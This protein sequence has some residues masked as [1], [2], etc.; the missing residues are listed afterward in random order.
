M[1]E[2]SVSTP[3]PEL[4]SMREELHDYKRN[5]ILDV[6]SQLFYTLGYTKT[7]IDAIAEQLHVTK[8]FVYYHFA[9]KAD[10]L[11]G[12]CGRTTALSAELAEAAASTTGSA[13][14]RLHDL[15]RDVTLRVTEGRIYLAV[16][17]REEMHLPELAKTRL[18]GYRRRFDKALRR[19]LQQGVDSGEFHLRNVSVAEQAISGMTTWV[20][21]WYRPDRKFNAQEIAEEMARLTLCMVE[22]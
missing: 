21:N 10:I 7:S 15:V 17:F 11:G 14:I 4:R 2:K 5:R 20:F 13:S 12:V 19:L 8:P 6:A 1:P 18:T 16:Y 9:S 3:G 22:A